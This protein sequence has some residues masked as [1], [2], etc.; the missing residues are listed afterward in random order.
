MKEKVCMKSGI[1]KEE[2]PMYIEDYL[3]K[4]LYFQL[5]ERNIKYRYIQQVQN[6]IKNRMYSLLSV[7]G[8]EK[9]REGILLLAREEANYYIPKANDDVRAFVVTTIRN[10]M[11]E[12]AAS[13]SCMQF[14][15]S[16]PLS[17]EEIQRITQEA[18]RFFDC[19]SFEILEQE[20]DTDFTDVYEEAIKKYPLAWKAIFELANMETQETDCDFRFPENDMDR[21][22]TI[23]VTAAQ[24]VICDG[25][26]LEFDDY[27]KQVI[28]EV[29]SGK[30]NI[31]YSDCFKMISRNFEK[32]LHVLQILLEN[33]CVVCTSNYYISTKCLSKRSKLVRASHTEKDA[34]NNISNLCGTTGKLREALSDMIDV[35]QD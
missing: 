13:N 22:R 23:K 6:D 16:E 10:S 29:I 24:T 12:I 34:I 3:D 20:L 21:D 17:N 28:G 5:R 15:M 1:T 30:V 11:L 9:K 25:Y 27:L 14:N 18:I 19:I 2:K 4:K 8:N 35:T 7:W 32:V 33:D 26:T 31:F